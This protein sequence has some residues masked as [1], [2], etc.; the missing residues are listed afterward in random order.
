MDDVC[1]LVCSLYGLKQ[2]PRVRHQLLMTYMSD[3]GFK[4]LVSEPCVGVK[5]VRGQPVFIAIY[6]DDIVIFA[7]DTALMAQLKQQLTTRFRMK[8]MGDV[9]FVICWQ[10]TRDRRSRTLFLNQ[11][12]YA[13]QVLKRFSM[14]NCNGSALPCSSDSRLTKDMSPKIDDEREEMVRRPYRNLVTRDA[15][16]SRVRS[17]RAQPVSRVH[18]TTALD[19]SK[20]YTA[21]LEDDTR[22][23]HRARIP[24][25]KTKL[26]RFDRVL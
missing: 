15:P 1:K 22:M 2:A 23:R 17:S 9:H 14:E 8:D 12:Q 7:P 26:K 10:V 13:L 20:A 4:M 5:I 3:M 19:G 16:R 11:H 25:V 6:V 18:R 21:V 24:C